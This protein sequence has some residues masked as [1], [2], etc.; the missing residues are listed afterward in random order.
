MCI[1]DRVTTVA[2]NDSRSFF[3]PDPPPRRRGRDPLAQSFFV[4]DKGGVFLSSIDLF[5]YSKDTTAPVTIEIRTVENGV[6]TDIIVP[7]GKATV[8]AASIQISDDAS[9]STRFTFK[10]PVY[11]TDKNDYVFVI[12]SISKSYNVW[13]SRLGEKDVS[14]GFVID[15][16]PATGVLFKSANDK[17][18]ISDQYEDIKFTLN[19]CKFTPNTSYTAILNNKPIPLSSLPNNPFTFTSSSSVINVKHPNHGMHTVGDQVK[20][21]NIVSDTMNAKLTTSLTASSTEVLLTDISDIAFNVSATNWWYKMDNAYVSTTN[22]GYIKIG[23]EI[24]SYTGT[25]STGL[26][27]CVRG[28]LETT[29]STHSKDDVV[30]C[31]QLNG[32]PL[33]QLNTT[34]TITAVINMDEY[35]VTTTTKSNHNLQSGGNK[36]L[37]S[38][39][40]AYQSIEPKFKSF[41]PIETTANF[42]ID[43][44]T[45]KSIGNA[46]QVPYNIKTNET[47]DNNVENILNEPKLIASATSITA[48]TSLS[49]LSGTLNTNI[50]LSTTNDRLSPIVDLEG[51]SIVTISNRIVKETLANG[52]LDLSSEILPKGGKHSAYITKKVV[53]ENTSTSVKVL[54][55]GIRN[56]SNE[57]RVF[58]KTKKYKLPEKI[59]IP[60]RIKYAGI[61]IT[62]LETLNAIMPKSI[63]ENA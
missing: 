24:I 46:T 50:E 31:Y 2:I 63:R 7:S 10:K 59:K 56:S 30:Q 53:L 37:G 42:T 55:D 28:A 51:S 27:G 58:V 32:I 17:T 39:N 4:D 52:T 25:T 61:W 40:I 16:Q 26:T 35:Q 11:L 21:S 14:T 36:V 23:D 18:W 38:R 45:G 34:H 49:S 60:A 20:F 3:V 29:A 33:Q 54:F 47:I 57:L 43:S 48:N 6:P 9:K 44:L 62:S 5:F 13:V 19:R 41:V 22:L 15:K 12:K 1:R 8:P